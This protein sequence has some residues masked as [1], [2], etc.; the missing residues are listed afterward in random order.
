MILGSGPLT[1]RQT[2]THTHTHQ[3]PVQIVL[4]K[5]QIQ[6]QTHRHLPD[7][8]LLK[9]PQY[10]LDTVCSQ[11]LLETAQSCGGWGWGGVIITHFLI[12]TLVMICLCVKQLI[13]HTAL[14]MFTAVFQVNTHVQRTSLTS[15]PAGWTTEA[16][17]STAAPGTGQKNNRVQTFCVF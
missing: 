14:L 1:L 9:D 2:R 8:R 3:S 16:G 11:T 10:S 15:G 12:F 6:T 17:C 5:S 13:Y 4:G 7:V